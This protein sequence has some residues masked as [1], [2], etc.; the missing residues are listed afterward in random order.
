[1]EIVSILSIMKGVVSVFRAAKFITE[2]KGTEY[3]TRSTA[4]TVSYS[5]YNRY[6]LR[7]LSNLTAHVLPSDLYKN[8]QNVRRV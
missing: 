2:G 3:L 5:L 4:V 1:M 8:S 7:D 6:K